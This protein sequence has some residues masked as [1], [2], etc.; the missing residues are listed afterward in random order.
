MP[1]RKHQSAFD[2]GGGEHV[3]LKK[4]AKK[5]NIKKKT[6]KKVPPPVNQPVEVVKVITPDADAFAV[7]AYVLIRHYVHRN[8]SVTGANIDEGIFLK[9]V[10]EKFGALRRQAGDK[11]LC[12]TIQS[13]LDNLAYRELTD[14]PDALHAGYETIQLE[15]AL[16]RMGWQRIK[17][18]TLPKKKE[19]GF[20]F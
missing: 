20:S 5:K 2:F 15:G 10:S 12:E 8:Y 17:T 6:K 19:E 13:V 4:K 7:L 9:Q 16:R 18:E 14:D 3:V 11:V 1:K